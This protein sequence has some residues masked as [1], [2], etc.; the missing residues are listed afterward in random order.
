MKLEFTLPT[1]AAGMAAGITKHTIM[2][3]MQELTIPYTTE[4][5]GYKLYVTL[6][7]KYY[8]MMCLKWQAKSIHQ[9]WRVLE[10]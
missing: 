3:K 10:A 8:T 4:Q 6:E 7:P 2:R 5:Q 1:G 9:R